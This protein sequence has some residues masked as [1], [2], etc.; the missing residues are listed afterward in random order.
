[1]VVFFGGTHSRR[2]GRWGNHGGVA[3]HRCA[4]T[5]AG[6]R[7]P[8]GSSAGALVASLR[9][10]GWMGDGGA[11]PGASFQLVTRQN[12]AAGFLWSGITYRL[13]RRLRSRCPYVLKTCSRCQRR[14][15]KCRGSTAM[16]GFIPMS[17]K[18]LISASER[19]GEVSISP[20]SVKDI[21]P[22]SNRASMRTS[23]KIPL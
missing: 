10:L 11:A 19:A 16:Q 3:W 13:R 1:M 12:C 21:Y 7:L 6:G 23:S 15:G 17:P 22:R 9:S 2:L 5:F 20:Q 8:G 4:D 18:L 14:Y